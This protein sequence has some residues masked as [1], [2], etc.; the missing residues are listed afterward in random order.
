VAAVLLQALV[1]PLAALPG[2]PL[3]GEPLQCRSLVSVAADV[4]AELPRQQLDVLVGHMEIA[5][6]A[7]QR[8]AAGLLLGKLFDGLDETMG[9][10][11]E[12]RRGAAHQDKDAGPCVPDSR[13]HERAQKGLR[14]FHG[15]PA[16]QLPAQV[17]R[18][19]RDSVG[20]QSMHDLQAARRP[21]GLHLTFENARAR[22]GIAS[23]DLE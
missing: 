21:S 3:V 2:R 19:S 22:F 8:D 11:L 7:D 10:H 17:T 16:G 9:R 12:N 20:H 13:V 5:G 15:F 6:I 1:V 14:F 18:F 23:T 4:Q